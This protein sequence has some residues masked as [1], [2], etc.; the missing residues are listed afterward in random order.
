MLTS[1]TRLAQSQGVGAGVEVAGVSCGAAIFVGAAVT[2][3]VGSICPGW[4][5]RVAT[6]V[7]NAPCVWRTWTVWATEVCTASESTKPGFEGR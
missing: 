3:T 5:V 2:C 4:A 6:I 1:S 7:S